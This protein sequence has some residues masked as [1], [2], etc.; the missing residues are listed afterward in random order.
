LPLADEDRSTVAAVRRG[1][2]EAFREIVDRH[3]D[4]VYSV[5][6]RLVGSPDLADELAQETF[7]RA[8]EGLDGFRGESG[9]RTWLVQIAINLVRDRRRAAR[10]SPQVVS[11]EELRERSRI[12]AEPRDER[13][14]VEPIGRLAQREVS[15]RLEQELERLPLEYREAF[16][17]KHVEGLRYEEIARITGQ[18]IGCLKVRTH[19]A[20]V[21]LRQ[22]LADVAQEGRD[23]GRLVGTLP[24]R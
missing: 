18:S 21:R 8:Y 10:R 12:D 17:L 15:K 11:L 2:T 1:S 20:R 24:R 5:L 23:H 14:S 7:V 4:F 19:R 9:L 22:A 13:A 3:G 16:V 6:R